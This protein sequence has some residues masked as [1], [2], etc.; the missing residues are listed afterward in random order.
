VHPAPMFRAISPFECMVHLSI[1]QTMR[2]CMQVLA[3][4]VC[5]AD[6]RGGKDTFED[7][8]ST[9]FSSP[10]NT[11]THSPYRRATSRK[12]PPLTLVCPPL[13]V[14]PNLE[15]IAVAHAASSLATI[16]RS[17]TIEGNKE[18]LVT[19]NRAS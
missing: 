12:N 18:V 14:F 19:V 9:G 6:F 16:F 5:Q 15:E 13:Q 7:E 11:D 3:R 10:S 2:L 4:N 1:I 17:D 8:A